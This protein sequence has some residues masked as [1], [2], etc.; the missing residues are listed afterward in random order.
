MTPTSTS[1]F[2]AENWSKPEVDQNGRK[3]AQTKGN[4]R[5]SNENIRNHMTPTSTSGFTT[6]YW[7]KPEVGQNGRKYAQTKGKS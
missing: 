6:D 4:S 3:Y 2:T 1:G 7:S 5:L